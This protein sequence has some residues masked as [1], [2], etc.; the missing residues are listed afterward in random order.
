MRFANTPLLR[1]TW[2]E[3][4][5]RKVTR[6]AA[7]YAVVAWIVLQVAEITYEPLGFP[8]WV[9]TWT[10]L[11]A[12]LGFPVVLVLAWLFDVSPRGIVREHGVAGAA[13]R[14]FALV[15]V[16]LTVAGVGGWLSTIY[17]TDADGGADA[18]PEPVSSAPANAIAVLPFDDISPA[19]DQRHLADGIA[20]ELLDRL[21][22][23]QGL[24]VAARTSSFALRDFAGDIREIGRLLDVRWVLEGSVRK[25]EGRV[26]ITAQL[27]DAA[28]GYHVWSETYERADQDLFALQDEVTGAIA[29]Q[30]ARRVGGVAGQAGGE[31][32][33]R[34]PAALELYL[35]G[36]QA[37]R[38]RTP[39]SLEQAERLFGQAVARDDGFAHAWAGL[40]DTYLIQAD[41]SIRP[42]DEAIVLA[43]PAAVRA[44]TLRP[45]LGE[46]WATLGLLRSMAGQREAG[47][48]SLEEAMR[49]DPRYEMAPMWL[50]AIYGREGRIDRQREVLERAVG[51]NPLEPVINSNYAALLVGVGD[52]DGSRAVLERVLAVTP[53]DPLLLR[54]L[55][56][57]EYNAGRLAR[58]L[59]LAR[60]A[61][62][63][64]PDAPANAILLVAMLAAV[65][66]FDAAA[67]QIDGLPERGL[68]RPFLRQHLRLQRGDRGIEPALLG[69][70]D[71]LLRAGPVLAQQDR[72]LL[73]LVA[74]ARMRAGEHGE[75]AAI[76]RAIVGEPGDVHEEAALLDP[77]SLL[78]LSLRA[79]GE[80]EEAARRDSELIAAAQHW[81]AQAGTSGQSEY[82]RALLALHTGDRAGALAKLQA[83]YDAGF[84]QRWQLA[85]DPRMAP[86]QGSPELA[87]LYE[88]IGRDLAD[89]RQA[90]AR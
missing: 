75:A 52:V 73:S 46:A 3:L 34:D 36:R 33:T 13:G 90:A 4:R 82:I 86:L 28:D 56:D 39:A 71:E 64:D 50:A 63:L 79:L 44:V 41:Y 40:A 69:R 80:D 51:L 31:M 47:K 9:L 87:A 43:E 26:R 61:H 48:R 65:E 5:R 2:S 8:D 24:R 23:M 11:G 55:A 88:R 57:T 84:R 89:A 25:G 83:A 38:Q 14:V 37:W 85:H 17:R 7:V 76:L 54:A 49:L 45:Q 81:E 53:D 74:T 58:A 22:R 16:L 27:I 15:V 62:A 42:L 29:T 59:E 68:L 19:R 60:R 67:Q 66:D 70:A 18:R 30:L 20:E 21:A 78:V 77:A 12:V 32:S 35:Q 6:A 72:D 10:V 1:L